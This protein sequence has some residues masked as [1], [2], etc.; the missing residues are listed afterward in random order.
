MGFIS[1]IIYFEL[2][3]CIRKKDDIGMVNLLSKISSFGVPASEILQGFSLH[4]RNIIYADIGIEESLT[5]KE[6][7]TESKSS[8]P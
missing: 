1:D 4:I 8:S 5:N 2:T 7:E 6:A 3:N